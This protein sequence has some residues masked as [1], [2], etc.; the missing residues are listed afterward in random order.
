MTSRILMDKDRAKLQI[1]AVVGAWHRYRLRAW[2]A[3]AR[4]SYLGT[5]W[6]S[7]CQRG[8]LLLSGF[9]LAR[10]LPQR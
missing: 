6:R 8:G 3:M 4:H 5:H 2:K 9:S 10:I 7:R 1:A